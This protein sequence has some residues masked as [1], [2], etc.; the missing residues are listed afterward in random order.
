MNLSTSVNTEVSIVWGVLV[1]DAIASLTALNLSAI[2]SAF[3]IEPNTD[4]LSWISKP[5]PL[6][7]LSSSVN[8]LPSLE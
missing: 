3:K 2:V 1:K 4:S 5:I 7:V 6:R 8:V